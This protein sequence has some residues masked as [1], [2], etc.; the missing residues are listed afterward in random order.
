MIDDLITKGTDEPYRMFTSRAEFRLHL[1]IDNADQRLTPIGQAAGLVQSQRWDR[2]EQVRGQRERVGQFLSQYRPRRGD[3]GTDDVF[4]IVGG[5]GATLPALSSLLKRP[6][7]GI[8]HMRD[9]VK[10]AT[11]VTLRDT[12]WKAIETEIKYDGYLQQQKRQM[13]RLRRSDGQRIP[14][15][16][17]YQGIPGLSHEIVERMERVRPATLGQAARIPGVTPAALSI[18]NLLLTAKRRPSG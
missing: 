13:E 16:F 17:A 6:E 18:L 12:E 9:V 1:R 15:A 3:P 8:E 11:G 5:A 14:G 10:G 7:V 2:F 4:A